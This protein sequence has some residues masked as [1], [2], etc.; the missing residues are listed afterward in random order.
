MSHA[1]AV[2]LPEFQVIPPEC[3]DGQHASPE[4][5]A[6][7]Y[8]LNGAPRDHP[9]AALREVQNGGSPMSSKIAWGYLGL[10]ALTRHTACFED[11]R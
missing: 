3:Q 7:N 8:L 5:H 1:T 6:G 2:R 11:L 10:R 4:R 9:I